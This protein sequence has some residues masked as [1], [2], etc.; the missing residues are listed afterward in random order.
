MRKNASGSRSKLKQ[1]K[2]TAINQIKRKAY[3]EQPEDTP[4]SI[5][6]V[7]NGRN[8]GDNLYF[9]MTSNS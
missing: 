4:T 6:R 3:I 2:M 9:G 8:V 7:K 1:Q 5:V